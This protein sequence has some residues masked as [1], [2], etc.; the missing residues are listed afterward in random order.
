M[1]RP[2]RARC[3]PG[4]PARPSTSRR[5]AASTS[6]A[7][8]SRVARQAVGVELEV[9][10]FHGRHA[11]TGA[12]HAAVPVS[13]G[14]CRSRTGCAPA[15]LALGADVEQH[16]RGALRRPRGADLAAV[17]DQ[18]VRPLDPALARHHGHQLALGAH[19]VDAVDQAQPPAR[20]GPRACRRRC[21]R[22]A[23]R[24]RRAPRPPS[25]ARRRAPS[26]AARSCAAPRR[27]GAPAGTPR[28]RGSSAS[29]CGRSPS[30]ERP[31]RPPPTV[32][33]S[34]DAGSGPAAEQ[35]RRD[36]VDAR[37][38]ALRREDHAPPAAPTRC[39]SR[40]TSWRPGTPPAAAGRT[41]RARAGFGLAGVSRPRVVQQRHPRAEA[42]VRR[43][44]A[45]QER[46]RAG[47]GTGR[48]WPRDGRLQTR[49]E[50]LASPAAKRRSATGVVVEEGEG[51]RRPSRRRPR[52]AASA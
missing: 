43:A 17:V 47:A 15:L 28:R 40:A 34:R 21:P 39:R 4:A 49:G 27:R 26:R 1:G 5:R 48:R 52:S 6:S 2:P 12:A 38:G 3:A 10:S 14:P 11:A 7:S 31:P 44:V 29:C 32:A 37:V 18:Q 24:P 16:A 33:A 25:C 22:A 50:G 8:R 42:T 9:E 36:L 20:C 19:R 41:A 46:L 45:A 13:A 23:R 51:R 35:P 30:A